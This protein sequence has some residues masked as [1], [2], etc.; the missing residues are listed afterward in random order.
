M[1][2]AHEMYIEFWCPESSRYSNSW[3]SPLSS[4]SSGRFDEDIDDN[5]VLSA[6]LKH[7]DSLSGQQKWIKTDWQIHSRSELLCN[8]RK[9]WT[10]DSEAAE[11]F[12]TSPRCCTS[13]QICETRSPSGTEVQI[14]PRNFIWNFFFFFF[15]NQVPS[16]LQHHFRSEPPSCAEGLLRVNSM[17]CN[18]HFKPHNNWFQSW[19]EHIFNAQTLVTFSAMHTCSPLSI[20]NKRTSI[21]A[22]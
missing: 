6:V 1:S 13:S 15:L 12:R 22:A 11:K 20:S 4:V 2:P 5:M 17:R 3:S 21:T 18:H 10:E 8:K 7:F 9:M 14:D 19:L 16:R